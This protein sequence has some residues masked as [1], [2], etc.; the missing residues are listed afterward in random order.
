MF[1]NPENVNFLLWGGLAAKKWSESKLKKYKN[2]KKKLIYQ[3]EQVLK[4]VAGVVYVKI[5]ILIP[6]DAVMETSGHRELE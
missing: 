4:V 2:W 1:Q 3:V 5:L 6:E